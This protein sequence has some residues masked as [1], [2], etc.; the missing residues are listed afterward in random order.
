MKGRELLFGN[1]KRNVIHP[2][3]HR[4]MMLKLGLALTGFQ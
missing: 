3:P 1:A 2:K 4:E